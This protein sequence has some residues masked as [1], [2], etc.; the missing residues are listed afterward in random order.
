VLAVPGE[1]RQ[2]PVDGILYLSARRASLGLDRIYTDI[3][4]MLGEPQATMLAARWADGEVALLDK[5]E[6]LLENM[7]EG[8]YV[9]LLDN[10]EDILTED[11]KIAE[12]GLHLFLQHCVTRAT[13]SRLVITSREQVQISVPALHTTRCIPLHEGL[14]EDDAITLLTELDPEG[15]LGLRDAPHDD[16]CR[17]AQL[18]QGIPRALE[19]LAGILER[20][21]GT[22][23]T[24]L[25]ADVREVKDRVVER[26]V[27]EG[28][29]HLGDNERCVMEA[30]PSSTVL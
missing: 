18:T 26:L 21:P 9:I 23:L 2:L 10:L 11:G 8:L 13:G 4:R 16:L 5:V 22:S 14:P 20:D 28:H 30:W 17:A 24:R 27:E 7:R 3:G 25:L 19:L 29:H 12:K 15:T 6:Y 1:E